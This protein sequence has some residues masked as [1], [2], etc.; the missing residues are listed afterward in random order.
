MWD[1]GL[2]VTPQPDTDIYY[3]GPEDAH[4]RSA[5]QPDLPP[6]QFIGK[7]GPHKALS[8]RKESPRKVFRTLAMITV[9]FVAVALDAGLGAGLPIISM[10]L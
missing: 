1:T 7:Q 2:Q 6:L 8:I 3:A 5:D 10:Q 4:D 9:L